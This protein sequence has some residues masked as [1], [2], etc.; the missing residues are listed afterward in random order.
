[1]L[2][3]NE[4]II[5]RNIVKITIFLML[6]VSL[7][8]GQTQE[9]GDTLI[10]GNFNQEM[11]AL[12]SVI[13]ADT[14]EDGTKAHSVYKLETGST[15]WI[16]NAMHFNNPVSIVADEPT[17]KQSPPILRPAL[18]QDGSLPG[19]F[20]V[21]FDD[22]KLENLWMTGINPRGD[23]GMGASLVLMLGDGNKTYKY[24]GLIIEHPYTGWSAIQGD[25]GGMNTL[26]V[27]DV[28]AKNVGKKGIKWNG[29]PICM[30]GLGTPQDS[31]IVTNST[32]YNYGV[33]APNIGGPS[34]Y[35]VYKNNTYANCNSQAFQ[36]NNPIEAYVKNNVF[37]NLYVMSED[38]AEAYSRAPHNDVHGII[39][40][41]KLAESTKDSLYSNHYAPIE[42][43]D[44]N[45][46]LEESERIYELENN[47]NY[48][49]Q[50][51][52]DWWNENEGKAWNNQEILPQEFM[53]DYVD[54]TFFQS[55]DYPHMTK[56]NNMVNTDPGFKDIGGQSL[57]DD[58]VQNMKSAWDENVD[59]VKVN[60]RDDLSSFPW[61]VE[62][63]LS[64][65]ADLTDD[66]GNKIGDPDWFKDDVVT[67]VESP[68]NQS[69]NFRLEQNYPNPFNPTTNIR[70]SLKGNTKVKLS[71]YNVLGEKVKTLINKRQSG[72]HTVKWNATNEAGMKVSSGIYFYKIK[73]VNH[74][75]MKKMMLLK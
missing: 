33:Y 2:I 43:D 74:T 73:T 50:G 49:T 53:I 26:I 28:Y 1:M 62:E 69:K 60:Y 64:Y 6:G 22:L 21:V 59:G 72:T 40:F 15:Y 71:I 39:H 10:V 30:T 41:F 14:T 24:D 25:N 63:D 52:K 12:D 4:G 65:T 29:S 36:L 8:L 42:T 44:G 46:T 9:K 67:D 16:Q 27:N 35:A 58:F 19:G 75:K 11:G 70:Y 55:D 57:L 13:R 32:F 18:K 66:Q 3:K 45:G 17:E 51:V 38:T 7:L 23:G 34:R 47:S 48:W 37:Y 31:V 56:S 5:M 54:T 20:F 61:P 68:E